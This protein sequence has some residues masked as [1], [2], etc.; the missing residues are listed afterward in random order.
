ME[1]DAP[2]AEASRAVLKQH[3]MKLR[4]NEPGVRAGDPEAVHDMRVATR[5]LRA[6]L[7]VLNGIAFDPAQV[8][9]LRK[10]LKRLAAALGVVRDAEVWLES[11]AE[12][13]ATLPEA[14]RQGLDPLR[15]RL[16]E[17]RDAGREELFAT[18]ERKR[19]AQLLKQLEHF[20]T[21]P[22]AGSVAA[23]HFPPRVRDAA[24]SAL[25]GRLEVVQAFEVVMPKAPLL[26]LHDLRIACK[27]LRY[28][29][30][31]FDDAL[32]KEAK[33]MHKRL[34]AAQ[35]HLGSLHDADVALPFIDGLLEAEPHNPALSHYRVYLEHTRDRL[36]SAVPGVWARIGGHEFRN[37]LAGI[38]AAL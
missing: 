16:N 26:L 20:V 38:I 36:W 28:T 34:V 2:L 13:A 4:A 37:Q 35:D 5:R 33:R 17:M 23:E 18:L 19:T 12:Y 1:A 10:G 14:E 27:K 29:I 15:Q 3:W 6:M 24:G 32:P 7:E 11:L 21:T 22:G 8:A 9:P 25:W 30:E 31:L